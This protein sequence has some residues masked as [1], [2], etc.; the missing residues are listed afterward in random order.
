MKGEEGMSKLIAR[1]TQLSKRVRVLLAVGAAL[2]LVIFIS[3]AALAANP[4]LRLAT[5]ARIGYV[6]PGFSIQ[7]EACMNACYSGPGS[8]AEKE[9]CFNNYCPRVCP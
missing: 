8:A 4:T 5:S 9:S 2:V 3:V 6:L 7:C 1:S